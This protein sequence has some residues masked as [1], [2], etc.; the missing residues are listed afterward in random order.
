MR[1]RSPRLSL[2]LASCL[3]GLPLLLGSAQPGTPEAA[4]A[5]DVSVVSPGAAKAFRSAAAAM[6]R[7]DCAA[8]LGDLAPLATAAGPDKMLAGLVSGFYAHTCEQLPLAEERLFVTRTPGGLLE[9]WRLF[10]LG[11]DAR[12][13]G[14]VL[15]AKAALAKLLGDYPASPLRP[16]ALV[17]AA[18]LDWQ[19]GD[20]DGAMAL[21]RQARREGLGGVE[22]T[23]LDALAWE[24]GTRSGDAKVRAEAARE[25]LVSS[26]QVAAQLGVADVFRRPDGTLSLAGPLTAAQLEQ[27][28]QALLA[29]QLEPNALATLDA[30]EPADRDLHWVLLKAEVLTRAHRGADAL[31]LLRPLET[32]DPSGL[33]GAGGAGRTA[34]NR[35]TPARARREVQPPFKAESLVA[36]EW[37]LAQAADDAAAA[38]HG[39]AARVR[40]EHRKLRLAAQLHLRSVAELG[41]D[42]ELSIRALRALYA[43][44]IEDN[45]YEPALRA[46]HRLRDLDP[47]DTTGANLLWGRGWQDFSRRNYAG[48]LGRW[49]ELTKLYP[50]DSSGRRAT[51]WSARCFEALGERDRARQLYSELAAADTSDF[52]RR[53][54]LVRLAR[55]QHPPPDS[56]ARSAEP[57]PYDPALVR[58]QLLSDLGLDDLAQI[59]LDLVRGRAQARSTAALQAVILARRGERR[60]SVLAIRDAFPALGGPFQ[61]AVPEEALKLYYP[62]DYEQPIRAAAATNGLAP[63]LVFGVIRQESAFDAAAQSRAGASGL[64]QLMPGTAR[65]LARGLGLGWSRERLIDPAWNVQVGASYLHQVLEMFGGNVEL[66]LAGYNGGPYRIKRLWREAG[67]S[68]LDRFLEGLSI[69][70]SK[71]YVKRILVLSDSYGRLY[72]HAAG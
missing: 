71:V 4:A 58:A 22:R 49:S 5:A 48:A 16:R 26:P 65:E 13:R 50:T 17:R 1:S 19:Q 45:S 66:A 41:A 2:T 25:L 54:A 3:L 56:A 35:E 67:S 20:G 6:R 68:D 18:T 44:L 63:A 32:S 43:H 14:H 10:L 27:R 59:E 21:V 15:V 39:R 34:A 7:R 29:L 72:P 64:M 24:I 47:R 62:L 11:D 30:V 52:Y 60:K 42:P 36:L 57:W 33:T 9:D 28:A 69:E 37:A 55:W 51:Y 40:A 8:A 12:A 46:L 61:A 31:A 70:E 53:N 38:Q 23:R